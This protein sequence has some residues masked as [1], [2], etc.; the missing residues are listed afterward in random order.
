V[1]RMCSLMVVLI[2][3]VTSNS[4]FCAV[5]SGDVTE[6]PLTLHVRLNCEQEVDIT[7]LC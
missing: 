4:E 7:I 1:R 5:F 6:K 2:L 3:V